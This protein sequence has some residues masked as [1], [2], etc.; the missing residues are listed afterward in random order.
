MSDEPAYG[1]CELCRNSVRTAETHVLTY[2]EV[3]A[4]ERSLPVPLKQA[5]P[6]Y[7]R[8]YSNMENYRVC[9][10]C[11][12]KISKRIGLRS[13]FAPRE[14]RRDLRQELDMAADV[15]RQQMRAQGFSDKEIHDLFGIGSKSSSSDGY[16]SSSS[17]YGSS[18]SDGYSSPSSTPY[19]SGTTEPIDASIGTIVGLS[20]VVP[21]VGAFLGALVGAVQFGIEHFL[22][23]TSGTSFLMRVNGA[24]F[25]GNLAGAVAFAI[26]ANGSIKND[27]DSE[28]LFA[29]WIAGLLG[30]LLGALGG[31]IAGW[32]G[33]ADSIVA[34][35]RGFHL[36]TLLARYAG[37]TWPG[38]WERVAG[39]AASVALV[40][41][42]GAMVGMLA[43]AVFVKGT[44]RF[45]RLGRTLLILAP[46]AW[47]GYWLIV[48]S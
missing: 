29:P 18:Y 17:S 33:Y 16:G 5:F 38:F 25:L 12:K 13:A 48:R 44:S 43:A 8:K 35:D 14:S 1:S 47:G 34:P 24:V 19:S 39:S 9:R 36:P 10:K 11:F 6:N 3:D 21:F 42:L 28:I 30:G 4:F 32:L 26:L 15:T 2:D 22:G 40:A 46:V 7:E 23:W 37:T 31:G 27:N 41:G 20:F 45:S